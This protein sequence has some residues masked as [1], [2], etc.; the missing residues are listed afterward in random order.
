M[1]TTKIGLTRLMFVSIILE[2]KEIV[3]TLKKLGGDSGRGKEL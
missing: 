3:F 2:C 1:N